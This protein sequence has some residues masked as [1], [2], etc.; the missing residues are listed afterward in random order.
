M[1][2]SLQKMDIRFQLA[3][4][5]KKS[6][7]TQ[8]ARPTT[9]DNTL[10]PTQQK[11]LAY[12]DDAIEFLTNKGLILLYKNL[13]CP[14]GELDLVMRD[15]QTLVFVEVRFRQTTAFGGAIYSLSKSKLNRFKR[16]AEY[17]LPFISKQHFAHQPV[18]CRFDAICFNGETN[19]KIWLKNIINS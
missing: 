19:E 7:Y 9:K 14:L 11:G 17:F 8:K 4:P 5:S 1:T 6:K 10:S 3:T 15:Q 18:Y 12:E 13:S 16:T 2:Y